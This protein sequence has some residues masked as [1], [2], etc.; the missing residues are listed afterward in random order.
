MKSLFLRIIRTLNISTT[1]I[2]N[3][4]RAR[5]VQDLAEFDFKIMYRP[6]P[7]NGGADVLSSRSELRPERGNS[8]EFQQIHTVLKPGHL[9]PRNCETGSA[10]INQGMVLCS[11]LQIKRFF[12]EEYNLE[13][14][15]SIRTYIDKGKE[16]QVQLKLVRTNKPQ[17]GVTEEDSLLYHKNCLWTPNDNNL[18]QGVASAEH[19]S[20]VAGHFGLDKTLE[21][22][23]RHVMWPK[24]VEWVADYVRSG[25]TCQRNKFPRHFD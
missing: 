11:L 4:R 18:L 9:E 12:V 6:G 25:D 20:L 7:Q 14:P 5:W 17:K 24:M 16:Y 13:F 23:T 22:L 19:D 15:T 1:K 2:L 8:S 21:L 10:M 3:R